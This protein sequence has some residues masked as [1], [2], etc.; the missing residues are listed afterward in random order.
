MN[1][2]TPVALVAAASFFA[3][4]ANA[5]LIDNAAPGSVLTANAGTIS[6]VETNK[7]FGSILNTQI[8]KF[9]FKFKNTGV[10]TLKVTDV[11]ASCGCTVPQLAKRDYAPGEEGEITGEFNPKSKMGA[12]HSSVTVTSNDPEHPSITLQLSATVQKVVFAEPMVAQ[13]GQV[14]KG[15]IKGVDVKVMGRKPDFRATA[16]T[17]QSGGNDVFNVEIIGEPEDYMYQGEKLRASTLRVTLKP[18]A[19][20]GYFNQ[21]IT[22]RTN[23]EREDT[24]QISA[25]ANVVGDLEAS[26]A[27][28]TLGVIEPGKEFKGEFK[29]YSK[30]RKPFKVTEVKPGFAGS[31]EFKSSVEVTSAPARPAMSINGKMEPALDAAPADPNAPIAYTIKFSGVAPAVEGPFS[32]QVHVVTDVAQEDGIP[33]SFHAAVRRTPA[34]GAAPAIKPTPAPAVKPAPVPAAAPVKK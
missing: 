7:D 25:F 12:A 30:G 26:P 21:A 32:G 27:A 11:H 9:I 28:V 19:K 16:A 4:T 17:I 14:A 13:I 24:M 33:I 10:G 22:V 18:N 31:Q 20:V 15:D 2:L 34:G 6:F 23:D 8:Q 5:Q 29:V 3:L 1:R